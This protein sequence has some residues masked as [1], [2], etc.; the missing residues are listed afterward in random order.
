MK[1]I[2][3]LLTVLFPAMVWAAVGDEFAADG[4]KFKVTS[5]SPKSVELT[6]YDGERPT[7]ALTIPAMVKDYSVTSIGDSVFYEC[8]G[9]T[10][11][12]IS[13]SVTSFGKNVLAGCTGLAKVIVPAFDVEKWCNISFGNAN[14][15]PLT[16]A[17]HLYS[18]ETTEI[19]KIVIP[20]G[21]KSIGN[22]AFY[23]WTNLTSVTIPN[24]VT[25]IG[26]AVFYGCSSLTSIDIPNGVTSVDFWTFG[27]SGLKSIEIPNSVT[28]IGY[29]AFSGCESLVVVTI[30][31]SVTSIGE[32]AFSH[33]R[34]L[35]SIILGNSV[36]SIEVFVFSDCAN[37]SDI[38]CYADPKALTW[39][40][41]QGASENFMPNK[42]TKCHVKAD[43]LATYK[44]KFGD[45]NVTFVGDLTEG[46]K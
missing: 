3:F 28:S 6:G 26:R 42:Q 25:S 30:P 45:V 22:W 10:S 40:R 27:F 29:G 14:S 34:G 21:V 4:L 13:T 43:N 24:S 17:H 41:V 16:F 44:E 46:S 39:R 36:T 8:S 12:T 18:D 33:C 35:T 5:E 7:G 38:Y 23:K 11:I 2:L 20:N 19:T 1:K 15:N 9:L 31:N 32:Y 37:L